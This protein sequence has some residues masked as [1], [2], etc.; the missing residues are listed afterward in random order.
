MTGTVRGDVISGGAGRDKAN[1]DKGND[2]CV[3]EKKTACE[4]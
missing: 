1:G 3:A 2:R 4:R